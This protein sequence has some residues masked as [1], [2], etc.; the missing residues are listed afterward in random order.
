MKSTLK[1]LIILLNLQIGFSQTENIIPNFNFEDNSQIVDKNLVTGTK[2]QFNNRIANWNSPTTTT[3]DLIK[4]VDNTKVGIMVYGK[5]NCKSEWREYIQVKLKEEIEKG[6]DYQLKFKIQLKDGTSASNNLGFLF[7]SS[8][9]NQ[10]TCDRIKEIP[11][12]KFK[13]IIQTK[14]KE[15]KEIEITFQADND[16]KYLIIGNFNTDRETKI[17]DGNNKQDTGGLIILEELF[18]NVSHYY[19]DEIKLIKK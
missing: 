1:L 11:Q 8:S 18:N 14:S 6:K 17:E 12:I 3:P 15:W 13:E 19:L 7:R 4:E 5:G 10:N 9:I 16:Y 2:E